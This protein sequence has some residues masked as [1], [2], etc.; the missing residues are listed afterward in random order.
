MVGLLMATILH[1]ISVS[2]KDEK[3]KAKCKNIQNMFQRGTE[4]KNILDV[5]EKGIQTDIM[6]ISNFH[7]YPND[8]R[9]M[10]AH[11]RVTSKKANTFTISINPVSETGYHYGDIVEYGRPAITGRWMRF[12]G[13][14][15]NIARVFTAIMKQLNNSGTRNWS[16]YKKVARKEGYRIRGELAVIEEKFKFERM[17]GEK[18]R[19]FD[20]IETRAMADLLRLPL[21]KNLR[22]KLR[23]PQS[24]IYTVIVNPKVGVKAAYN[25]NP[26][27]VIAHSVPWIKSLWIRNLKYNV[28]K[29]GNKNY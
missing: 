24:D 22:A 8:N 17:A 16:P 21:S 5:I 10:I 1:G 18:R 12:Q 3:L 4:T 28:R 23:N 15:P 19:L 9:Q 29:V 14:Y 27:Y 7:R 25:G 11:T 26:P 20:P 2:F 6:S 13:Y